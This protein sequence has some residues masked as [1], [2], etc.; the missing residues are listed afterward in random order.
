M[1]IYIAITNM[2]CRKHKDD[3]SQC[4]CERHEYMRKKRK[5]RVVY[6]A[7]L[8]DKD[9]HIWFSKAVLRTIEEGTK[10]VQQDV[11]ALML[12]PSNQAKLYQSMYVFGNHVRIR[13]AQAQSTTMDFGV[14]TTFRQLCRSSLKDTIQRQQ[15]WST[16]VR[17]R[18]SYQ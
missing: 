2:S 12:L 17:W 7:E 11:R 10:E 5:A 8:R 9:F 14:A 16:W 18:K 3:M 6:S 4:E 15:S 13:S 1:N